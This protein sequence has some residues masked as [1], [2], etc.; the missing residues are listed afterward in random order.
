MIGDSGGIEPT[1]ARYLSTQAL[2]LIE[3][4]ERELERCARAVDGAEPS[5][6]DVAQLALADARA[7]CTRVRALRKRVEQLG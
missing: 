1:E 3:A 2:A 5:V 4:A 7:L 6:R